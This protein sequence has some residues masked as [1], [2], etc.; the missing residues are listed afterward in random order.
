VEPALVSDFGTSWPDLAVGAGEDFELV[1][2]VA[3]TAV[4]EL[5]ASW[6]ANLAP[7]TVVGRLAGGAA[8]VVLDEAGGAPVPT[9]RTSSRHFS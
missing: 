9:P 1:V 3:E 6:P 2:A 4:P 7:L 5:L 8:V